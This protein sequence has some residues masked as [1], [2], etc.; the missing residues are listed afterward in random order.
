MSLI[1]TL[2]T[3]YVMHA[4]EVH[5]ML[6]QQLSSRSAFRVADVEMHSEWT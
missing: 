2:V 4:L 3:E 5:G 6:C 1:L